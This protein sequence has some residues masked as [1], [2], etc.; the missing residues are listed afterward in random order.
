MLKGNAA[1]LTRIVVGPVHAGI[2]EPG[3]FTFTS[4]GETITALDV[5][6]GFSHRGVIQ[7]LVGSNALNAARAVA[8]I[9]GACSASRS[10]TYARALEELAGVKLEEPVELARL[11]IAELERL[12][13]HIFDLASACAGAGYQRGQMDGLRLKERIHR[14][15]AQHLGHRLLFDTIVPGG[16]R[17]SILS[18][19]P[20]LQREV[21][22]LRAE[23]EA[24][25]RSLFRTSSL[26]NRFDGAGRVPRLAAESLDAVGPSLRASSGTAD[27]RSDAPYGAY[28]WLRPTVA[29]EREGD[30]YARIRVK[31]TEARESLRLIDAGLDGLAMMIIPEV[32]PLDGMSGRTVAASEGPRGSESMTVAIEEDR[33]VQIGM[34]SASARNWPVVI[35]A[36]EG[37]II[38][39][40]PLVNKSF[41]LCYACADL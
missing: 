41:N 8:R 24:Y 36:M 22:S 31:A 13:N 3:R 1:G 10:W 9:C 28:A 17:P 37:N 16:A 39:D 14:L 38:P 34:I 4:A 19:A 2:I 5:Q 11:V 12:Y 18:N 25:L 6:L 29:T 23:I 35:R 33:I 40:F 15:C 21:E 20:H 30:V 27:E 26:I 32:V 7:R